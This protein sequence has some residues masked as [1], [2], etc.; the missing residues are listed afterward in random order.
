MI[1]WHGIGICL[2]ICIFFKGGC[3]TTACPVDQHHPLVSRYTVLSAHCLITVL[4]VTNVYNNNEIVQVFVMCVNSKTN[5][6]FYTLINT[7]TLYYVVCSKLCM[8]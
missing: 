3:Y 4:C 7:I 5:V 8:W 1:K 2:F 6:T